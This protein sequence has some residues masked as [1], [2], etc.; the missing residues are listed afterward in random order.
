MVECLTGDYQGN[1]EHVGVVVDS[2]PNVYA[3]NVETVERLTPSVRDYRAGYRQSLKVL[4]FAKTRNPVLFTKSSLMVG[5]GEED[6]EIMQAMRDLRSAGVDFLT[7][8]QYMRPSKKHMKVSAYIHPSKF[9]EYQ[10][11]GMALGFKYVA[12]GPLVRSSYRAGELYI[13]SLLGK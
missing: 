9:D 13:K 5:C 8:G 4:E 2:G 10:K 3:H 11:A 12:S 7:I 6:S 1:L